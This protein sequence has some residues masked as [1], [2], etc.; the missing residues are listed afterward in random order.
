MK[1]DLSPVT[2]RVYTA[3]RKA[4]DKTSCRRLI[5]A[6]T[7]PQQRRNVR[8]FINYVTRR[9][10]CARSIRNFCNNFDQIRHQY[11]CCIVNATR[12][13]I[14]G[15]QGA[16][17]NHHIAVAGGD[18]YD[19]FYCSLN[20]AFRTG[21]VLFTDCLARCAIVQGIMFCISYQSVLHL[22]SSCRRNFNDHLNE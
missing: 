7:L 3:L 14:N 22:Y 9:S 15:Y 12:D 13:I 5:H 10:A 11:I 16:I 19:A 2:F 4:E 18:D 21:I 8:S 17:N 20:E 1:N 6:A